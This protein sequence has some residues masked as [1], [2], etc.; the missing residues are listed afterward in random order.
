MPSC[1]Q[2]SYNLAP[3]AVTFAFGFKSKTGDSVAA[4]RALGRL[5]GAGLRAANFQHYRGITTGSCRMK[6]GFN[7][8]PARFRSQGVAMIHDL[9]TV[10]IAWYLAFWLR[11]NLGEFPPDVD[12]AI[13]NSLLVI[14][15]VQAV[16][17]SFS[18]YTVGCGGLPHSPI[19]SV[20]SR[21]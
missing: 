17:F 21:R 16:A 2:C 4:S 15:P 6:P 12:K 18:V 13:V 14:L 20:L 11:Y 9:L 19:L 5:A 3:V 10:P 1:S 7:L 8:L